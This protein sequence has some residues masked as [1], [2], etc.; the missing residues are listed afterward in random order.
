MKNIK[1]ILSEN[2]HVL[3]VKFSVYSNRHV[4]VMRLSGACHCNVHYEMMLWVYRSACASGQSDQGLRCTTVFWTHVSTSSVH[5][6]LY[7]HVFYRKL[8]ADCITNNW[9]QSTDINFVIYTS[10]SWVPV[11]AHVFL[12]NKKKYPVSCWYKKQLLYISGLFFMPH[13]PNQN[14]TNHCY[15]LQRDRVLCFMQKEIVPIHRT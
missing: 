10:D 6:P 4:F 8:K 13:D 9:V 15:I 7:W 12:L 14:N 11:T 2:F 3:V 1:K 5:I